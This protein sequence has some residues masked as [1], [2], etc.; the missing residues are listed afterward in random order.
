MKTIKHT[1]SITKRGHKISIASLLICLFVSTALFSQDKP[2][3]DVGVFDFETNII[4]YGTI[5]K[6][7][8]GLRIFKFTNIG[9][10]PIVISNV[11]TS[12]GCTVPTFS[13]E[14]VLSGE[15]GVIEIKYATNRVG[16]FSKT[17]T[18]MSNA[19]ETQKQLKIKGEV[20]KDPTN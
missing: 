2:N 15:T 4:D 6:N 14:P 16:I 20:L 17:I 18:V 7:D 5:N 8:D 11:K 1:Q 10:A 12:C 9:T 13:K 3:T 19:D